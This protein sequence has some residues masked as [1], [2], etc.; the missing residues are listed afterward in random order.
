[1]IILGNGIRW[2]LRKMKVQK[3]I[4]Q[5]GV[6]V[7]ILINQAGNNYKN[8]RL[9]YLE[10]I[11]N[12]EKIINHVKRCFI[13]IRLYQLYLF[14]FFKQYNKIFGIEMNIDLVG[15]NETIINF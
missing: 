3:I 9:F 15:C 6:H 10:F 2:C 4:M 7:G 12:L 14:I 8:L 13:R 1:M 5:F 11:T